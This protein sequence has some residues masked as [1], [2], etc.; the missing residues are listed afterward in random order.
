MSIKTERLIIRAKKLIKKGEIEEARVIYDEILKDFPNNT[1]ATK[2]LSSL[3]QEKKKSPNQEQIEQLMNFYS[4]G[5]FKQALD[6]LDLLTSQFPKDAF[7]FNLRGACLNEINENESSIDSFKNAITLN[8]NYAEAHY[9]L[10]VVYQKIHHTNLALECYQKAIS[11]L[12]AY[13]TAHNNLGII[14]L[15]NDQIKSAVK[16]FEWAIAYSPNYSQAHNNLGSALQQ[17]DQFENAKLH[18][19]KAISIDPSYA[20]AFENLG[21]VCEILNLPAEAIDNFKKALKINPNLTNSYRNLSRLKTFSVKDQEIG[22]MQSLY[23]KEDLNQLDKINLSFALAKVYE[24]LGNHD[25]FFKYLD[26]ANKLRKKALNYSFEQSKNFHSVLL[27][28]FKSHKL[29]VDKSSA[30]SSNIRP[31]FIVGMPRSGTSLVEQIISSHYSVY[32]A[33]EL[34][35]LRKAIDPILE[36]TLANDRKSLL[37]EDLLL[38]REQYLDS[39][40]EMGIEERIITD[41]MPVNF[42]LIGFILSAIPEAKIVHVKRDARAIC[43]SN[44]NHF[45]S[46]GNGF[47]FSQNDLVKFYSLYVEIMKFW[48]ELFPNKIYDLSYEKMTENQKKETENLLEY[49]E[50]DWDDNCLEFH[51]NKRG[52]KT[53]SAS[54]VRQKIYQGSSDS[55]KKYEPYITTLIKGLKGF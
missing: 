17:I 54:Q 52:V 2:G 26:K 15:E 37:K 40:A 19:E 47:S 4:R 50:L 42:R 36:N 21:V 35:N 24:D 38:I 7:L 6:F 30:K 29:K 46:S 20:Q 34:L 16:S 22:M 45:F 49:C 32:G 14:F 48:H 10:G 41:K 33:G 5:D 1:E 44:Y 39:L 11:F 25:E 55:W 43:W 31:I 53:A 28:L 12:H 51:K 27:G 8:E 23:S 3:N 13:P 18:F 9:N